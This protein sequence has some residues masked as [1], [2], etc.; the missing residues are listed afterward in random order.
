MVIYLCSNIIKTER[1][2]KLSRL[3]EFIDYLEEQVKIGSIYVLGSQGQ[4]GTQIT[5]SWIKYR[6]HY[7]AYNYNRAIALWKERIKAGFTSLRAYDCSGLGI[8]WLYNL[9]RIF[10]GD[11]SANGMYGKCTP[12]SRTSLKK[13][14]W[15]FRKK[16]T[17]RKY[18]IGYIVDDELNVIESMGRSDGVVK[19]PL[20]ASGTS[21]WNAY[22]R[23]NAFKSEIEANDAPAGYTRLLKLVNPYMSGSDV[24]A[25]QTKLQELGYFKGSLGGN[26][27][28]IT[29]AA[30]IAFQKANKLEVDGIVGIKTWNALFAAKSVEPTKPTPTPTPTVQYSR[31]LKVISPYMRGDDVKAVQTALKA[32]GYDPKGIDGVYGE[33]TESAVKAF[34]KAKKI[35]VDGIVGKIT[36]GKLIG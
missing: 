32:A 36:W 15:V 28:P 18:H 22:G 8:Y 24:L 17:G 33:N 12:I 25:V 19:R 16:T 21:Y 9:K 26:F 10:S 11:L 2:L 23:P 31:L 14:D 27:G 5:E 3:Q 7:V 30:V 6:E 34:Q 13:G 20:N 29:Q 4:T 1:N 35:E